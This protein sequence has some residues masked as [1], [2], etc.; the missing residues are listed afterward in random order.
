MVKLGTILLAYGDNVNAK[1]LFQAVISQYPNTP[2]AAQ[3]ETRLQGI[4]GS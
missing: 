1:K 4:S 2:G 3:A